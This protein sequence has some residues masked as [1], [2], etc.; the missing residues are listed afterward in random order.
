MSCHCGV[1][2]CADTNG[3]AYFCKNLVA[4]QYI[5]ERDIHHGGPGRSALHLEALD[6]GRQAVTDHFGSGGP[7]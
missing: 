4:K 2:I 1:E 5:R 6:A 3:T 7:S